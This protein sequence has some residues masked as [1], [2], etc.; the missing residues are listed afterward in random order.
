MDLGNIFNV[1]LLLGA[2]SSALLSFYLFFYPTKFFAN[3]VLGTLAFSWAITVFGFMIQSPEFHERFPH[4]Y[5]LL[6]V[7]AIMFYPLMYIYLRTYLYED[8]RKWKK[9][10]IHLLPGALY[11]VLFSPFFI[12]GTDSKAL[13]IKEQSFPVWY[14]P[15]QVVFN[16]VIVAQ[17]IFYSILSLRKLHH[18][19]YFRKV[20]LTR[21]QLGSLKWL[22]LFISL[23]VVLWLSGTAGF[24]LE[25][26]QVN[27]DID[28]F[29]VFYLGLTVLTILLGVF[30]LKRPEFFAEEE[31]IVKY[32]YNKSRQNIQEETTSELC[33]KDLV[34]SYFEKD[35]PYLKTDLKMQDLVNSTGLSYKR[36]SEIFNVEFQKS[37]FD[38][39]NDYRMK[40]AIDLIN[41][42]YHRQ[43]TLLHLAEQAGFNSKTTFNRTFKKYTGQTPTEYIQSVN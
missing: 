28:L 27:I 2:V 23:N 24:I 11:L 12:Q 20:R 17:G 36:I 33:D 22:K 32:V 40:T 21:Y 25:V 18:F 16:L 7:F 15:M 3:K 6:D 29:A 37:F 38:I 5:A 19:Q 8:T 30:T 41:R 4:T 42:G 35:M 43:H 31:D 34:L 1:I 39:V 10:M 13:M 9:N 26:L 14:L